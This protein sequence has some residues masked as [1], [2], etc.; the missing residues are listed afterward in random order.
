MRFP[1]AGAIERTRGLA[2]KVNADL[3]IIDKRRP[4]PV[5]LKL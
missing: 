1:D 3:A 4:E 5:N 2:T